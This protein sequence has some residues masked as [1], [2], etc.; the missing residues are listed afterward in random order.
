MGLMELSSNGSNPVC[1]V[2]GDGLQNRVV[3]RLSLYVGD[4]NS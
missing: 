4:S 2:D 1:V 3:T